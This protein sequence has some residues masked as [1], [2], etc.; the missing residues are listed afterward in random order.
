M[1][2]R[3]FYFATVARGVSAADR[4]RDAGMG[5]VLSCVLVLSGCSRV[6]SEGCVGTAYAVPFLLG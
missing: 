1:R 2:C 3:G 4:W 5:L 6:L